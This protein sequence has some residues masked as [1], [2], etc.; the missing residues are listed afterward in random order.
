MKVKIILTLLI[1][2]A[3]II[4]MVY[5]QKQPSTKSNTT[6][7]QTAATPTVETS[8][9]PV[10]SAPTVYF[11]L[12]NYAE[13][14]T[15]RVYGD[16]IAENSPNSF[17]CGDDFQGYH[18][19]D[20][21]EIIGQELNQEVPVFAVADGTVLQANTVNGYGGLIIIQHTLN[22]QVVTANYGHINLEKT[23]VKKGDTVT[24]GQ[25]L[26]QL[27]DDCSS[28]TSN[29]RK[30]LHFA[31]H[32]GSNIVVAGYLSDKNQLTEWFNPWE[33]LTN[34]KAAEPK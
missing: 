1:L 17:A 31:I 19:G 9:A 15:E 16:Y 21:L 34:L 32:K 12:T 6:T 8:P 2:A 13:R 14:T 22:G 18:N 10:T 33:L 29:E 30:H 24:A 28:Q 23:T 11:P 7:S 4:G 3:I 20:D 26:S 25:R 27:G 5:R